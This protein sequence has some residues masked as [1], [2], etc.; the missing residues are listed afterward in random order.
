M[1][2]D[3]TYKHSQ[4]FLLIKKFYGDDVAVRSQ[5]PLIN[6]VYE[7]CHILQLRRQ[8]LWVQRAFCLHPIFQNDENFLDIGLE[9]IK[10]T[11]ADYS[12]T[13][14]M[15][16]RGIANGYLAKHEFP[17]DGIK[18]S[19]IDDVNEML[20]ADKVQN[21][22]DFE[23]YHLGKHKNSDR[24]VIYFHEWLE[25]LSVSESMYQSYVKELNSITFS[26]IQTIIE[27]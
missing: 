7:G 14:E 13:C 19:P 16:Y 21:R 26:P 9:Y 24:L 18:L 27:I 2:H 11:G 10:N 22:K 4:E 6:H 20:I 17:K 1:I 25:A 8:E 5:I 12:V 3:E 15:E 23:L